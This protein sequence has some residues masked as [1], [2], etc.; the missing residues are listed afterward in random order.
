MLQFILGP[1]HL[2]NSSTSHEQLIEDEKALFF[3]LKLLK[4]NTVVNGYRAL[5]PST[6]L[7]ALNTGSALNPGTI[8]LS[9]MEIVSKLKVDL[10]DSI[11]FFSKNS[12]ELEK[13]Q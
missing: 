11:F 4:H 7:S 13:T 5:G 1:L 10:N 6:A 2:M 9:C 3:L 8:L 12:K